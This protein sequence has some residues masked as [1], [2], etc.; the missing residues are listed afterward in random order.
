MANANAPRGFTPVCYMSGKP[1]NSPGNRYYKDGAVANMILAV[2]DPVIRVASTDPNGYPC[3]TRATTGAAITGVIQAIEV[4][5]SD[6]SKAGA[7][8]AADSGY[9]MVCDD[10][11]VLFEVQEGGS[12]TQL[13]IAAAIGKHID[14]ITAVDGNTL[15]GRSKYQLDNNAVASA[16]TW[17]IRGLVDRPDNAVGQYA[18]WLVQAN[19][20][21]DIN[22][23]AS[24]TT[25]V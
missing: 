13:T 23:S 6:L 17:I 9:V 3:I 14:S 16:N 4:V 15:T 2:G 19:L 7:Y 10:P 24:N 5:T 20:H 18:K 11:D 12:G 22:A 25:E 1:Y 8:A 21:T